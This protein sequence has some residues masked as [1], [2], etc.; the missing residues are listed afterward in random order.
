MTD[1]NGTKHT[2]GAFDIRTVIALLFAIYG[3]VLTITG[4]VQPAA[5]VEKAAGVNIN[6]WAGIGMIVFAVVFVTW[7]RLR[8]ILVPDEPAEGSPAEGSNGQ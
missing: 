5:E 4:F 7:A 1:H 6:L 8:P 2:A 3:I